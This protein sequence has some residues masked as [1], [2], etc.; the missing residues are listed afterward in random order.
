MGG[1]KITLKGDK[2]LEKMLKRCKNPA[3]IKACVSRSGSTLQKTA[4][5]NAPVD[6]GTL[7]RSITIEM[8]D[9]GMTA[10][11]APHVH[12]AAYQELGTRFI[13]AHP[14]LRPAFE[15]AS[16]EFKANL[17]KVVQ[18]ETGG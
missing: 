2:E 6:T 7:R 13:P 18:S 12:Y 11:V 16:A 8:K 15:T 9:G 17:E 5:Q 1:M 10:E 14:Y 3:K 4:Q